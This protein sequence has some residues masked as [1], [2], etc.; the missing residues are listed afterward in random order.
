MKNILKS[1]KVLLLS[2]AFIAVTALA[3]AGAQ[4][5]TCSFANAQTYN[6]LD[7]GAIQNTFQNTYTFVYPPSG[8]I[9]VTTGVLTITAL[10]AVYPNAYCKKFKKDGNDA[11]PYVIKDTEGYWPFYISKW[12][13]SSYMAWKSA[14]LILDEKLISRMES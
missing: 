10:D 1:L 3:P 5:Y 2:I 8:S 6:T 12:E 13:R 9:A 14:K 11:F 4:Q 7:S